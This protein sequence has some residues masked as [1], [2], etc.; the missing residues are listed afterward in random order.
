MKYIGYDSLSLCRFAIDNAK[1]GGHTKD[2]M[3]CG[4]NI[5]ADKRGLWSIDRA[6]KK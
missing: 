6:G 1:Q 2:V 4:T 3:V 5:E